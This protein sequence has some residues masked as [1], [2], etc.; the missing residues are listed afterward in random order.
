MGSDL[1][2]RRRAAGKTQ[3]EFAALLQGFTRSAV[4]NAETGLRDL[5]RDFWREC[6]R[7]LGTGSHFAG[8]HDR[9]CFGL[10]PE[11]R[12]EGVRSELR[13]AAVLKTQDA[14]EAAEAYRRLGWP[15]AMTAEGLLALGTGLVADALEVPGPVGALAAR[16][17]LET[18]GREDVVRGLPGLPR[19]GTHLAAISA[20][21]RWYFLARAGQAPW[22]VPGGSSYGA[23]QAA[24]AVVW[25]GS[26]SRVPAPPAGSGGRAMWE[27]LPC[28]AATFRLPA[29]H[30][31]AYL[32]GRAAAASP[33]ESGFVLPGGT[34]VTPAVAW[35]P[36]QLPGP[37]MRR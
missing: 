32:L 14:A 15:V 37:V 22:R 2:T 34:L 16:W 25:H 26:G 19:P 11:S 28:R 9:V 4:T 12:D 29:P 20:G 21:G 1:R 13:V 24:Q 18:G 7:V 5:S 35:E 33:T 3:K 10:E 8:W 30:A 6:D 27:F 23:S 36:Q 17:W 31:V